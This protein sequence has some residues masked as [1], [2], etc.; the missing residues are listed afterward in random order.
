MIAHWGS[1]NFRILFLLG[2]TSRE[3]GMSSRFNR[4]NRSTWDND[5]QQLCCKYSM[6]YRWNEFGYSILWIVL[7]KLNILSWNYLM[8]QSWNW[9]PDSVMPVYS[10][11]AFV[12]SLIWALLFED[13]WSINIM[14]KILMKQHDKQLHNDDRI[15]FH[16]CFWDTNFIL[17]PIALH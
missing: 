13:W 12:G 7:N 5:L 6:G 9:I 11:H 10:K 4:F 2:S 15:T 8:I 16:K 17:I 1:R 14:K 3:L